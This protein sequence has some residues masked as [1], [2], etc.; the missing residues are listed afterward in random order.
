[1]RHA[2]SSR[3]ECDAAPHPFTEAF[4][5][6][7]RDLGYVEGNNIA[8]E[9]RYADAQ[10]SRALQLAAEL[11]QLQVDVIAA[12]HTPAVKAAM[13]ATKT[14]PIVMAPAGAPLEMG[15]VN[16]LARPGGNVTGLSSMEA[17]L[18]AR[19]GNPSVFARSWMRGSSLRMTAQQLARSLSRVRFEGEARA[20]AYD[21]AETGKIHVRAGHHELVGSDAIERSLFRGNECWRNG[22]RPS[23][24]K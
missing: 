14:I 23:G 16:S 8:I 24:W 10:V 17:E 12:Y 5:S 9:W 13:N 7:L 19:P 6:G 18:G 11:V 22:Q 1:M 15:L 3:T 4:R 2:R 20:V 21:R